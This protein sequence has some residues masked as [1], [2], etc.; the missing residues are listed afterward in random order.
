MIKFT[1]PVITWWGEE[2]SDSEAK[3]IKAGVPFLHDEM[4]TDEK[5]FPHDRSRSSHGNGQRSITAT[6]G[7]KI[8]SRN[9]PA[10]KLGKFA[11]SSSSTSTSA[12]TREM[13]KEHDTWF[14]QMKAD[15]DLHTVTVAVT[16]QDEVRGRASLKDE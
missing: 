14:A 1:L 3:V 6:T 10:N 8:R 4:N 5:M 11:R 13:K 2:F 15:L 7:A 16:S 9:E 12:G